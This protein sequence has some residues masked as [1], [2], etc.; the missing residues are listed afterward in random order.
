MVTKSV[1]AIP[2]APPF[3]DNAGF[4]A[5]IIF[6]TIQ[7]TAMRLLSD[8]FNQVLSHGRTNHNDGKV[9]L[10][11]CCND[12]GVIMSP[13]ISEEAMKALWKEIESVQEQAGGVFSD[14]WELELCRTTGRIE[15]T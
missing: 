2:E 4:G 14:G 1:M 11:L 7:Y 8:S 15:D 13:Y 3:D 6:L 9:I 10:T 12:D 5:M